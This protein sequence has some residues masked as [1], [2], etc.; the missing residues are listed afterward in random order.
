MSSNRAEDK[1]YEGP[2]A[3]DTKVLIADIPHGDNRQ[4]VEELEELRQRL[5]LLP[6]YDLQ[7]IFL[8][9]ITEASTRWNFMYWELGV[10]E[11]EEHKHIP[12]PKQVEV[13]KGNGASHDLLILKSQTNRTDGNMSKLLSVAIKHVEALGSR[14]VVSVTFSNL[15]GSDLL[16]DVYLALLLQK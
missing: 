12:V 1:Y 4:L 5:D 6:P 7:A 8:N 13:H 10:G 3:D 11:E 16:E 14:R 9:D 15:P 2:L